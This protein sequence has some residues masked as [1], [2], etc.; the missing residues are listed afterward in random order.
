MKHPSPK[1]VPVMKANHP[2]E[3]RDK[4]HLLKAEMAA[5]YH[6]AKERAEPTKKRG[7]QLLKQEF[8]RGQM[9]HHAPVEPA[10]EFR[11]RILSVSLFPNLYNREMVMSDLGAS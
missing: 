5:E 2:E 11:H 4:A 10:V 3:D 8:K 9:E 6:N 1:S 7:R